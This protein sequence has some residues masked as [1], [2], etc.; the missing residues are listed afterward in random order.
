VTSIRIDLPRTRISRTSRIGEP[1]ARRIVLG[2]VALFLV[3]YVLGFEA[4]SAVQWWALFGLGVLAGIAVLVGGSSDIRR[5]VNMLVAAVGLVLTFPI[6]LVVAAVVK[7][8]SPGPVIF[9]QKR[10]G[11]DRRRRNSDDSQICR[12]QK[13][14]G[15]RSFEIYKFRTM[16]WQEGTQAQVWAGENDPRI[17]RVGAVLRQTRL[18]ELP[19]L[20]NVLLGHMNI[21]GP[22]PEQPEIFVRLRDEVEQYQLRQQVMPGITGWAQINHHYDTCLEDVKRKVEYDLEY[23]KRSSAGHDVKIMLKTVPVM[24]GRIGSR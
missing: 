24:V 1:A 3:R 5:L 16:A 11:I 21:V 20:V 15:G 7:L 13:D 23:I 2:F 17:N 9:K 10:V 18:D 12:R 14:F 6:L 19:Q 8:G 4:E 22:R